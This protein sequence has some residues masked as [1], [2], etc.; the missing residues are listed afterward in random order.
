MEKRPS[1]NVTCDGDYLALL[2]NVNGKILEISRFCG[3]GRVPRIFSRGKNVILEFL[4]RRDG[5]ATHDGFR[6][7]L[8]EERAVPEA[9]RAN[10]EFVYRSAA[11]SPRGRESVESPRSWYPPETVCTYKFLGRV[12]ERV[13]VNMKILRDEF[14]RAIKPETKR[15]FSLN[16]CPGNEIAVYDGAQV[17]SCPPS[18]PSPLSSPR[19]CRDSDSLS[20]KSR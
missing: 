14:E 15:N 17:I 16:I 11:D 8:Q 5:T 19:L 7:T 1:G 18:L 2:E 20:F 6:L 9:R 3:A 13:S 10:C 4:A 12:T